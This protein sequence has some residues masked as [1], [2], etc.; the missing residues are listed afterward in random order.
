M[1]SFES[2]NE[3]SSSIKDGK[4]LEQLRKYQVL[5]NIS[6][7]LR[8]VYFLSECVSSKVTEL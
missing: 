8:R 5:K 2:S 7:L 1:V 6:A 3:P 4:F